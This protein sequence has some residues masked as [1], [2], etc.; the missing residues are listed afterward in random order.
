MLPLTKGLRTFEST[1]Q[2][3]SFFIYKEIFLRPLGYGVEMGPNVFGPIALGI[4]DVFCQVLDI[5]PL[6][7]MFC[8]Q[9]VL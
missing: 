5:Y 3:F 9:I 4:C 6:T 7:P 8:Q 1:P 2:C